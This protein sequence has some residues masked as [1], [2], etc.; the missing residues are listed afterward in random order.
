MAKL[1]IDD[2]EYEPEAYTESKKRKY[3]NKHQF[4]ETNPAMASSI[5][6][7]DKDAKEFS[8]D[9]RKFE[10]QDRNIGLVTGNMNDEFDPKARIVCKDCTKTF[11][12]IYFNQFT[13][14]GLYDNADPV[15]QDLLKQKYYMHPDVVNKVYRCPQCGKTELMKDVVVHKPVKKLRP[16]GIG[17]YD[18]YDRNY[19][20]EELE[21]SFISGVN[22]NKNDVDIDSIWDDSI[23]EMNQV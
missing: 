6:H 16:A 19:D 8:F 14:N 2:D 15:L 21:G 23:S 9:P 1:I 4:E 3:E 13:Q 22:E 5:A 7:F 11:F 18:Q 12:Q 17:S 20:E 10:K